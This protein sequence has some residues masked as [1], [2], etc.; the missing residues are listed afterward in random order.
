MLVFPRFSLRVIGTFRERTNG[1]D[2]LPANLPSR[3]FTA[4]WSGRMRGRDR[5]AR[6]PLSFW[7]AIDSGI[8]SVRLSMQVASWV[9]GEW[10]FSA[11]PCVPVLLEFYNALPRLFPI[12]PSYPNSLKSLC[13]IEQQKSVKFKMWWFE[14]IYIYVICILTRPADFVRL[15]RFPSSRFSYVRRRKH[16]CFNRGFNYATRVES[17]LMFTVP[18][19]AIESVVSSS[20]I[21]K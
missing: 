8:F 10:W 1:G 6:R 14:Y 18:I 9:A 16:W 13:S 17:I 21:Q 2:K 15:C 4:G 20:N 7:I 19:E 11:V 12:S 5:S 3:R